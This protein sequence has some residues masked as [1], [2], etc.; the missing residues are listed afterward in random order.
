MRQAV[1]EYFDEK[2]PKTEFSGK[3][4]LRIREEKLRRWKLLSALLLVTNLF[5]L[6]LLVSYYVSNK[7]YRTMSA[8]VEVKVEPHIPF[9]KLHNFL[10]ENKLWIS[11]PTQNGSY[12]LHGASRDEIDK[13]TKSQVFIRLET[14]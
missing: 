4:L 8:G 11:G 7:E 9:E 12:F 5:I 10:F 13:L 6:S 1:K 3:V 14:P 2:K